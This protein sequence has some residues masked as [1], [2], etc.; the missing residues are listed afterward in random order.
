MQGSTTKY[1]TKLHGTISSMPVLGCK[2][3]TPKVGSQKKKTTKFWTLRKLNIIKAFLL[4]VSLPRKLQPAAHPRAGWEGQEGLLP[5]L[6][7]RRARRVKKEKNKVWQKTTRTTSTT[8]S[9]GKKHL[10]V[11]M[12][13]WERAG[14]WDAF[15]CLEI[16]SLYVAS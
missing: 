5:S 13:P 8:N 12:L 1:R 11:P 15:W 16:H 7:L 4:T 10:I 3:L 14:L 9:N 2:D 6:H